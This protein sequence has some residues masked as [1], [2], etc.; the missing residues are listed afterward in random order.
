MSWLLLLPSRC[1]C[2][3]GC[4]CGGGCG[5]RGKSCCRICSRCRGG[6]CCLWAVLRS[7]RM[8]LSRQKLLPHLLSLPWLLLLPWPVLLPRLMPMPD[9]HCVFDSIL[10]A[11]E[12]RYGCGPG[13]PP[14]TGPWVSA[15]HFCKALLSGR[16]TNSTSGILP[17]SINHKR[18]TEA[19][20]FSVA[21]PSLFSS[22]CFAAASMMVRMIRQVVF[23]MFSEI[24]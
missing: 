15:T 1:G 20:V 14:R 19:P 9:C 24:L 10:V 4:C 17:A 21:L 11:A 5:C 16:E 8:L 12:T 23:A 13:P 2:R 22:L 3:G 7:W 18:F 6:C